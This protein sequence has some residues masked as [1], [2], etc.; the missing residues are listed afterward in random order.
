MNNIATI[1]R[2]YS[3]FLDFNKEK[4]NLIS[5]V[6]KIEWAIKFDNL[7]Y[8]KENSLKH[9][10]Y[11]IIFKLGDDIW[12]INCAYLADLS[13]KYYIPLFKMDIFLNERFLLDNKLKRRAVKF[14]ENIFECFDWLDE[15]E[16]L[17]DLNNDLYYQSEG[18]F[19]SKWK[20]YFPY[21]DFSN[22]SE[23]EKIY[24]SGKW[25][26]LLEDFITN[27]QGKN[28]IISDEKK[29]KYYFKIHSVFLYF[30]YLV[31]LLAENLK[32]INSVEFE[33]CDNSPYKEHLTL[34][35][36]RVEYVKWV[37]K[38]VFDKYVEILEIFFKIF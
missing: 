26:K 22:I 16:F 4:L 29:A 6:K 8:T 36:N 13:N 37:E 10:F 31:F 19:F 34:A 3:P 38:Q 25:V 5:V 12:S 14:L 11:S 24:E 30:I 35:K 9:D 15:K 17:I 27:Y 20:K 1:Y 18:T 32:K 33:D 28:I 7:E 23:I 2:F 21:H